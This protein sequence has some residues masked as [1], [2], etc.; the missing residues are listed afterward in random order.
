[1]VVGSTDGEAGPFHQR[2]QGMGAEFVMTGLW[3]LIGQDKNSGQKWVPEF[4]RT[5]EEAEAALKGG[6]GEGE[7][8]RVELATPLPPS[9]KVEP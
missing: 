8:Y 7:I 1:M 3:V 5:R 6:N 4:Y 9:Q 2:D